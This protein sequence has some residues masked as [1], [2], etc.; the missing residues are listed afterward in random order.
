MENPIH[1]IDDVLFEN[2]KL[3]DENEKLK[4]HLKK[5]TSPDKN[6]RF[7]QNHKEEMIEKMKEYN[8]THK[9]SSDKMKEYNQRAYVK[10]K[11]QK[12]NK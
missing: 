5:Y 7:Y 3:K 4:N 1:N 12:E 11:E 10:R 2:Q 8:K 9:P 6:K